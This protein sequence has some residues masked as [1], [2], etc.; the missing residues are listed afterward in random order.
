MST[1][2][3]LQEFMH[4]NPWCSYLTVIVLGG[5]LFM[6]GKAAIRHEFVKAFILLL[7]VAA[8]G[9]VANYITVHTLALWVDQDAKGDGIHAL[10]Y[11]VALCALESGL[12]RLYY[13]KRNGT[14]ADDEAEDAEADKV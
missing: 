6:A 4:L 13:T 12:V 10:I 3:Q 14:T 2:A 11:W 7:A 5:A 8:F 1:T 9:F